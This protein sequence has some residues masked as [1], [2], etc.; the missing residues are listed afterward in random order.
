[1]CSRTSLSAPRSTVVLL[2]QALGSAQRLHLTDMNVHPPNP[3]RRFGLRLAVYPPAQVLQTDRCLSHLTPASHVVRGPTN[4]GVPLLGGHYSTSLLLRTPPPPS[5]LRPF[6]R[7]LRLYGLPC[8][9]G[10]PPGGGGLLQLLRASWSPCCRS[11]P[12]GVE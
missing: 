1:M 12:A 3:P 10:F 2:G 8:S 4:S 9:A 5:P 11:H 6:S 7:V